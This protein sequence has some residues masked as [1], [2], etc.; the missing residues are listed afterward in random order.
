MVTIQYS[1]PYLHSDISNF[2]RLLDLPYLPVEEDRDEEHREWEDN[3]PDK[4]AHEDDRRVDI[5]RVHDNAKHPKDAD[6]NKK[7]ADRRL[8][9]SVIE[10]RRD[11]EHRD[12]EESVSQCL[13]GEEHG[14]QITPRS[15]RRLEDAA[16]P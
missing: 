10:D 14:I 9:A 6:R 5:E 13:H 2:S 8:E 11:Q 4:E 15:P 1:S 3:I 7:P 12:T 16:P